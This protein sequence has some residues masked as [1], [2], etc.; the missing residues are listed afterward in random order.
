MPLA[1]KLGLVS[2]QEFA[3]AASRE[4]RLSTARVGNLTPRK[5]A[6]GWVGS[7][8]WNLWQKRAGSCSRL[9]RRDWTHRGQLPVQAGRE[10]ARAI[11]G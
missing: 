3:A 9:L 1:T 4:K 8:D 10:A 7:G 2:S 6:M 5:W 11:S